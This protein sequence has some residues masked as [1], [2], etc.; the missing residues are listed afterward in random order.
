MSSLTLDPKT[1][2]DY[3]FFKM[4]MC[5]KFDVRQAKLS[6]QYYSYAQFDP[7]PLDLKINSGHLLFMMY[8][9]TKFEVSQAKGS[10][11]TEWSVYSY[12]QFD[13]WSLTLLPQN[14]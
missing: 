12:V 1:N 2:L 7:W 8:Q 14:Q 5:T 13:P 9:C 4:Y 6:G 11:D 3:L 10:Q